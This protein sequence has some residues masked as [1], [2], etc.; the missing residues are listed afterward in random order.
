[1]DRWRKFDPARQAAMRAALERAASQAR[2]ADFL[3]IV[4]KSLA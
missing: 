4:G 2:S 3:E 1:M